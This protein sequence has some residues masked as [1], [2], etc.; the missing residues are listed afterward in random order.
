MIKYII[1][2]ICILP[3]L[4]FAQINNVSFDV[5]LQQGFRNLIYDDKNE[6]L[7]NQA[8]SRKNEKATFITSFTLSTDFD[9]IA[10]LKLKTGLGFANLGYT[11]Q[12]LKNLRWPSE[13]TPQGFVFD[14]GLPHEIKS[15]QFLQ[16]I[17]L[18]LLLQFYTAENSIQF[19]GSAGCI[20]QY[21]VRV[22]AINETD[23]SKETKSG[24]PNGLNKY[25]LM[26]DFELGSQIK[27]FNNIA[28]KI[29]FNYGSQLLAI[30]DKS[31]SEKLYRYGIKTSVKYN[32]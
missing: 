25:N 28:C 18:P 22:K 9:L 32:F 19:Y 7:F 16:Y 21:M 26:Y 27:V 20:N 30:D 13:I 17:E 29:G 10:N 12:D 6:N 5:G 23:L 8:L 15:K 31:L 1:A 4:T 2:L 24:K 14:P 3:S 11:R